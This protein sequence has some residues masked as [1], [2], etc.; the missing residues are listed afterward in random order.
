M[1]LKQIIN[2][3]RSY[4]NNPTNPTKISLK[5]NTHDLKASNI[6]C[7]GTG[8]T[9]C[10]YLLYLDSLHNHLEKAT[11]NLRDELLEEKLEGSEEWVKCFIRREMQYRFKNKQ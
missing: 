6:Y 2:T 3:V 8:C 7:C 11:P 1:K 9:D 4:S 10:V 5:N